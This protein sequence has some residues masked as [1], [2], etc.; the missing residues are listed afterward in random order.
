[1]PDD[2]RDEGEAPGERKPALPQ[3]SSRFLW[4][5]SALCLAALILGG[6][7]FSR[8]IREPFIP[9]RPSIA[10]TGPEDQ[11]LLALKSKDTDGDT[12]TDY[13]ELYGSNTSPYIA[14][15][16]S[17]GVNDKDEVDRGTDPNCPEGTTCGAITNTNASTT[18]QATTNTASAATPTAQ[19]IRDALVAAGAAKSEVDAIDD[20]TLLLSYQEALAEGTNTNGA[21]NTASTNTAS[22]TQLEDL[23]AQEIRS[24]LQANGVSAEVLNSYDDDTLRAVY[25]EAVRESLSSSTNTNAS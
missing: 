17:D 16:D 14:D 8:A 6:V 3:Q 23:S 18:N 5:V 9:Q 11:E 10:T 20:A 7:Q 15:S 21:T 24:L 4:F 2:R 25:L 13:D 22:T 1:M 12:L 19:Q